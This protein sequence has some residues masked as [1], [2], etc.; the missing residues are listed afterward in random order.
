[1][2]HAPAFRA[3]AAE[4]RTSSGHSFP[5]FERAMGQ[6]SFRRCDTQRWGVRTPEQSTRS[7]FSMAGWLSRMSKALPKGGSALCFAEVLN[8]RLSAV[9]PTR[10]M[11]GLGHDQTVVFCIFS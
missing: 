7:R 1:M 5:C 3:S 6:I 9:A 4:I 11:R 2:L 10:S 8:I